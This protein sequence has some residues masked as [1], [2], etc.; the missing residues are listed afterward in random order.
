MIIR[1]IQKLTLLDYPGHTACTLFTGGCNFRCPFCHNAELVLRQPSIPHIPQE[2]IFDFLKRRR[3]VLDGICIS[4]GE[5]LCQPLPQIRG[6][7]EEIRDMG[8][9]VKLDTNGTHPDKLRD[10]LEDGLLD[11]VAMDIKAGPDNYARAVGLETVDLAPIQQSIDLLMQG[12]I[13]YEFRTTV[14][15]GIHTEEDFRA[16]SKW[17]PAAK[18]YYLQGFR[19]EGDLISGADLKAW[20]QDSMLNFLAIVRETIHNAQLRGVD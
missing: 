14:V 9:L 19:N 3:N 10:L 17:I 12:N 1:G 18:A 4:G 11:M 16:I 20:D 6:L 2:D 8:F 5:P 15:K 7:I 13:P